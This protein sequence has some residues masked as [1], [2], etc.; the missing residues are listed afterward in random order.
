[1]GLLKKRQLGGARIPE[2]GEPGGLLSMG[3]HRDGQ[4]L[5]RLSSSS[6]SSGKE[7]ACQCR[8]PLR[9][10]S[11]GG[12]LGNPLQ[13]SCLENPLDRKAWWATDIGSKRVR[14]DSSNLARMQHVLPKF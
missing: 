4:G 14:Y 12:S 1:M 5:K 3:S 11:P 2:T 8:R 13:Y 7:L 9:G 10:R 6:S